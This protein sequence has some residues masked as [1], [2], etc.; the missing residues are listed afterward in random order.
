MVVKDEPVFALRIIGGVWGLSFLRLPA[1]HGVATG[2]LG[3][4]G[5]GGARSAIGAGGATPL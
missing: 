2:T 3:T 4:G 5:T 1:R